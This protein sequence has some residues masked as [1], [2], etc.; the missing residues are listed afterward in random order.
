MRLLPSAT[1]VISPWNDFSKIPPGVLQY[2]SERGTLVHDVCLNFHAKGLP[3]IGTVQDDAKG[4]IASFDNWFERM[5]AEVILV[6]E[7]LFDEANGYSGQIDLLVM[8]KQGE[9]WMPDLKTPLV[10]SKAWRVQI[11]AYRNLCC[12]KGYEP[13][14][15]GSLQLSP[16]GSLAKMNWY[17]GSAAQDF[18]IFLHCLNAY[19]YFQA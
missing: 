11:A 18:N 5:V 14:R 1:E 7:R 13:K 4:Y 15:S 9:I 12:L 16:D 8:T 19:R 17:E 3:F 6:E 2:A 10:K